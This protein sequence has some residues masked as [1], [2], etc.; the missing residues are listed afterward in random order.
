MRL[1]EGVCLSV[2]GVSVNGVGVGNQPPR[3]REQA[4][5]IGSDR[6]VFLSSAPDSQSCGGWRAAGGRG[7]ARG[8]MFWMSVQG[9]R[10]THKHTSCFDDL[11]MHD[12]QSLI[13]CCERP[14]LVAAVGLIA[15]R[16]ASS[17]AGRAGGPA[18]GR[19][20]AAESRE[21]RYGRGLGQWM[22]AVH[23]IAE[24]STKNEKSRSAEL[25]Q[26]E[27]L[28]TA[29]NTK[30]TIATSVSIVKTANLSGKETDKL[31]V[32]SLNAG[33][34]SLT[35]DEQECI[36]FWHTFFSFFLFVSLPSFNRLSSTSRYQL[37][38]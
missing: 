16:S 37:Y 31:Q 15:D 22:D 30:T 20:A 26:C 1:S 11:T 24:Q 19:A 25:I 2:R 18:A 9:E 14:G 5:R 38:P 21:S 7:E 4:E 3:R 28:R 33:P 10:E 34:I 8:R 12:G 27:G 17:V 29:V 32:L 35:A 36:N 23:C 13:T 6:T